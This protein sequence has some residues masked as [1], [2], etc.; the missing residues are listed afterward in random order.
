MIQSKKPTKIVTENLLDA[1]KNE[2]N[3]ESPTN[4]VCMGEWSDS[5]SSDESSDDED[6]DVKYTWECEH[7]EENEPVHRY[8]I[9]EYAQESDED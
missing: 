6:F 8:E 9:G 1:I 4:T 7:D 2:C 5:D 3:I